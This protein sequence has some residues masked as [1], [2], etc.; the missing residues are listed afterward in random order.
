MDCDL[1]SMDA[2]RIHAECGEGVMKK[3]EGLGDMVVVHALDPEDAPAI[4]QIRTAV[5]PQKGAPW[6]IESRK[7]YDALIEVVP[8]RDDATVESPTFGGVPGL[9]VRP[10]SN[11]SHEAILHV[12]GRRCDS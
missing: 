7:F 2:I 5:R 1:P 4:A 11:R 3:T 12:H 10:A 9:W 8:P 6:R